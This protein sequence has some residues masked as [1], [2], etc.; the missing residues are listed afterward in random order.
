MIGRSLLCHDSPHN[1]EIKVGILPLHLTEKHKSY[2]L[3]KVLLQLTSRR[4]FTTH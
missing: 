2:L 1:P 4:F 3:G